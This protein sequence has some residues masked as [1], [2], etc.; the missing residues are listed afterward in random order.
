[1]DFFSTHVFARVCNAYASGNIFSRWYILQNIFQAT[2][3]SK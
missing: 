2:S 3:K 1:M